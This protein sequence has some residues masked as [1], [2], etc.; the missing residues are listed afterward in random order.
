LDSPASAERRCR[1]IPASWTPPTS[2]TNHRK[3]EKFDSKAKVHKVSSLQCV[4]EIASDGDVST[5]ASVENDSGESVGPS[6]PWETLEPGEKWSSVLP[7]PVPSEVVA[8]A[9]FRSRECGPRTRGEKG[10]AWK[11]QF[12]APV[13]EG[14]AA[15][16]RKSEWCVGLDVC[17]HGSP[18]RPRGCTLTAKISTE[19]VQYM[20]VLKSVAKEALLAQACEGSGAYLLG[21]KEQP[22]AAAPRGFDA[23][24]VKE[25][26]AETLCKALYEEGYC[27][28]GS[29]C[30]FR[31]PTS[32]VFLTFQMAV[33]R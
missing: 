24:L 28:R 33:S 27:P 22:F 1:S 9:T 15:A 6:M 16:V 12:V 11:R 17:W 30:R 25:V 14:V 23:S 10:Q 18:E 7:V 13:V 3:K 31:H 21:H 32:C 8:Q 5:H 2:P 19:H 4:E 29:R 20:D 26:E